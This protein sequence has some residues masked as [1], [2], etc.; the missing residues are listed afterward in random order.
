MKKN[1]VVLCY[2]LFLSGLVLILTN[3][4]KKDD[5]TPSNTVKDIKGNVYKTVIIGTQTWMAENLRTTKYNDDI[6]IPLVADE[7]DW[8]ELTTPGY[9]WYNNDETANKATYG[10]LY[11]WYAVDTASNDSKDVCP[12]GWHVPT[13]AECTVLTDYLGGAEVAGGKLKEVGFTHW[14]SPNTDA[15]NESGFTALPGGGRGYDG[16]FMFSGDAGCWWSS[17]E[18][19]TIALIRYMTYDS[20]NVGR[21]RIYDDVK[22]NGYSVRCLKN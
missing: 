21:F 8:G 6:A 11:N 2:F 12:K 19:S 9:C 13:D 17:T 16:V 22:R 14:S 4:C 18:L 15:T 7:S 20:S 5:E 3:S 1:L 10:A